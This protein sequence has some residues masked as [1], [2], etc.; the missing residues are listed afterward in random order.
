MSGTTAKVLLTAAGIGQVS[1]VVPIGGIPAPANLSIQH[2]ADTSIFSAT[3]TITL[4]AP[5]VVAPGVT[6]TANDGVTFANGVTAAGTSTFVTAEA[7]TV[8]AGTVHADVLSPATPGGMIDVTSGMSVAGDLRVQ[9]TIDTV[10][11]RDLTLNDKVI[12]LGHLD[13]DEDGLVDLDDGTRDGAG[14][15]VGGAPR[16]IPSNKDPALYEHSIRW[17][18]KEGDFLPGGVATAPHRKPLWKVRGG[19]LGV[20]GPDHVDREAA[21]YFAPLYTASRASLGL[22]YG[23]DDGRTRLV[24]TFDAA[25]FATAAPVWQTRANLVACVNELRSRTF[26]AYRAA[27]YALQSGT[28]PPGAS[29]STA[30]LLTGAATLTGTYN[31]VVRAVTAD[32]TANA[33]RAF[34]LEVLDPAP[35]YTGLVAPRWTTRQVTLRPIPVGHGV[36]IQF[37]AYDPYEVTSYNDAVVY[38][39]LSGTPPEGC[40]ISASGLFTTNGVLTTLGDFTFT[41]RAYSEASHLYTDKTY[42]IKVVPPPVAAASLSTGVVTVANGA[43]SIA[44]HVVDAAVAA[45][46]IDAY[47]FVRVHQDNKPDT[48][49]AVQTVQGVADT[50]TVNF[51]GPEIMSNKPTNQGLLIAALNPPATVLPVAPGLPATLDFYPFRGVGQLRVPFDI[52]AMNSFDPAVSTAILNGATWTAETS[53]TCVTGG[54]GACCNGG[55]ARS[56]AV[57]ANWAPRATFNDYVGPSSTLYF[58]P[59]QSQILTMTGEF[60]DITPPLSLTVTR[61]TFDPTVS[62]VPSTWALMGLSPVGSWQLLDERVDVPQPLS[63]TDFGTHVSDVSADRVYDFENTTAYTAYRFV[64]RSTTGLVGNTA[65]LSGFSLVIN[66][67]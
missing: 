36:V 16:Y 18:R 14:L 30:G 53:F 37:D 43:T 15:V 5:T 63:E 12:T 44:L 1:Q 34:V 19:G 65:H 66:V 32:G 56:A 39:I 50:L 10:G 20:A 55:I 49:W 62:D 6:F 22:Y 59:G 51:F 33:D 8:V 7:Q 11:T 35:F 45:M 47:A 58:M 60:L 52:G 29:L 40:A 21:F 25:P 27:T 31:F 54:P 2:T 64:I 13:A 4:N 42:T 67:A 57:P 48:Y 41:L 46:P 28:L 26:V 24:H 9:G 38:S 3:S 23:I 61:Y 17:E